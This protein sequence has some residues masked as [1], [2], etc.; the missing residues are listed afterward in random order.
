VLY[1]SRVRREVTTSFGGFPLKEVYSLFD[2]FAF[3]ERVFGKLKF[4]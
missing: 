1:S 3:I 2:G 4:L